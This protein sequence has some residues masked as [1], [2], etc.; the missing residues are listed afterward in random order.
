L[1]AAAAGNPAPIPAAAAEK[2]HSIIGKDS[3]EIA[4]H[5]RRAVSQ[6]TEWHYYEHL[7]KKGRRWNRL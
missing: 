4:R 3:T 7:I 1:A 2:F 5:Q 6:M